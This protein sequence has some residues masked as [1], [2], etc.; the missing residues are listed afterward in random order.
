M[1][2]KK[3]TKALFLMLTS[4][5]GFLLVSCQSDDDKGKDKSFTV[6]FS[7]LSISNDTKSILGVYAEP[8]DGNSRSSLST[9]AII[10]ASSL[11]QITKS[12][13]EK[14]LNWIG[15]D[16]KSYPANN[17]LMVRSINEKY[18]VVISCD[19]LDQPVT[20]R[21]QID[22]NRDPHSDEPIEPFDSTN[23]LHMIEKSTGKVIPLY[24][25]VNIGYGGNWLHLKF[26]TDDNG[27]IYV[28]NNEGYIVAIDESFN[29]FKTVKVSYGDSRAKDEMMILNNGMIIN[30]SEGHF[31]L[32]DTKSKSIVCNDIRSL[33]GNNIERFSFFQSN[34]GNDFYVY[35]LTNGV[36]YN[37]VEIKRLAVSPTRT[38]SFETVLSTPSHE[39]KGE[40]SYNLPYFNNCT[41]VIYNEARKSYL[42]NSYEYGVEY[43]TVT[44]KLTNITKEQTR[45][46]YD[47]FNEFNRS[48]CL[49]NNV[50]Y[51]IKEEGVVMINLADYNKRVLTKQETR[52]RIT[53]LVKSKTS[54]NTVNFIGAWKSNE[55]DDY[56]TEYVIGTLGYNEPTKVI[57]TFPITAGFNYNVLFDE[58]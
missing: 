32:Y 24:D 43:N 38:F 26:Y 36:N 34:D 8:K 45:N 29:T 46:I 15:T 4:V 28:K 33:L 27:L 25:K 22:P 20:F 14:E 7:N 35:C 44:N 52:Y 56:D 18:V 58:F 31:E 42:I 39:L 2:T 37:N 11:Y 30:F 57:K 55:N 17:L 54:S 16:S 1:K 5:F 53:D 13:V 40:I 6:S 49:T 21:E 47:C 10:G 12:N 41:N 3:I 51:Y 19:K 48:A 9:R 50:Y 23:R